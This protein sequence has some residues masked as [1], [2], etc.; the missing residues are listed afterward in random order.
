MNKFR[1]EEH[2]KRFIF[3]TKQLSPLQHRKKHYCLA[4]FLV[5]LADL[6]ILRFKF[7]S[8]GGILDFLEAFVLFAALARFYREFATLFQHTIFQSKVGGM[9]AKL[10]VF[11]LFVSDFL[12]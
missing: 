7:V 6:E 12:L 4:F 9:S 11:V 1:C 2:S 8:W 5:T 3:Q 10:Q